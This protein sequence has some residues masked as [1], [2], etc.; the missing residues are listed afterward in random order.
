MI[1]GVAIKHNNK[2]Y[3]L[4]KPYRHSNL[5]NFMLK[6]VKDAGEN[7]LKRE[8]QGFYTE[9][10]VFLNRKNAFLHAISCGQ[11]TKYDLC[12]ATLRSEDLW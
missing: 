8:N 6:N 11:L 10:G 7:I 3:K 1:V 12:E 2:M 4:A 9:E 5:I